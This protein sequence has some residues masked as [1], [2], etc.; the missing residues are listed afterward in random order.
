MGEPVR[1]PPLPDLR[2]AS[3]WGM[4]C[5]QDA[6]CDSPSL[7]AQLLLGHVLGWSRARVLAHPEG[8]LAPAQR[9]AFCRL[10]ERRAAREPLAYLTGQRA[11]WGLELRV[12][13]GVLIPRPETELLVERALAW[14]LG[15]GGRKW[16]GTLVDV[17][18]GSG[19]VAVALAKELPACRVVATDL[20]PEALRVARGNTAAHGVAERVECRQGDLL[21]FVQGPVDA[22]VSNPPYIAAPVLEALPPEISR[23]EPRVAL[24][25][26][27][28]GLTVYRRLI[29]QAAILLRPGGALFLEIGHDQAGPMIALLGES[30][31]GRPVHGYRDLGGHLRV[32]AVERAGQAVETDS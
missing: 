32:L 31:S 29:P 24:D 3:A 16:S 28:D 7:D 20:S 8:P 30:F 21:S 26:G 27:P 23:Y 6:G 2:A 9:S 14:A 17:G 1:R 18:T 11:F 15:R 22:I 12:R 10:V 19:A 4:A 25:G 5:L 13:P